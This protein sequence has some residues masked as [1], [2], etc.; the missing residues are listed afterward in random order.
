MKPVDDKPTSAEENAAVRLRS[1][2]RIFIPT[3]SS[4]NPTN[5]LNKMEEK[6]LDAQESMELISRMIRNSRR[7]MEGNTGRPFLVWGY[8]TVAVSLLNYGFNIAGVAPEWSLT[9]FLIPI[10]G[11]LLMRLIPMKKSTEPRT[12]ID[13]IV[14]AVWTV[15]SLALI[16]IFIFT[17]FHGLSYRSSLLGMIALTMALGTAATGLILRSKVFAVAGFAGMALSMLFPF[18]DFYL[19]RCVA[20]GSLGVDPYLMY[21]EILIFA[22]IFVVMMIVPGHILNRKT[23]RR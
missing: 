7:R 6:T 22:L 16:P 13:R 5:T 19:K 2:I 3:D 12:D 10:A 4:G 17:M 23:H 20:N 11:Y 14:G 15:C 18:Y 8:T 21:N 9:W 1:R